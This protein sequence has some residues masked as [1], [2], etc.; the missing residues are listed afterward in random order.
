[1]GRV[2]LP[3]PSNTVVVAAV[4]LVVVAA[5][6]VVIVEVVVAAGVEVVAV[7]EV[8]GV[9]VVDLVVVVVLVA[10]PFQLVNFFY[11]SSKNK[12]QYR[13]CLRGIS[14]LVEGGKVCETFPSDYSAY[15]R[16]KQ[17]RG[18]L[19]PGRGKQKTLGPGESRDS[20]VHDSKLYMLRRATDPYR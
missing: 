4:E 7:V 6:V 9:G 2:G 14:P 10:L 15:R 3:E 1:M 13:T 12:K 18:D 5:E 16:S 11:K 20:S 19:H 17:M 8:V